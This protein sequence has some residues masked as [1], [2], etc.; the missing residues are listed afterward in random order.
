MTQCN[1]T[2]MKIF[3]HHQPRARER[4]HIRLFERGRTFSFF[5]S[6]H[7]F[8]ELDL[9]VV[10][11]PNI[12]LLRGGARDV[13]DVL[14]DDDDDDDETHKLLK[15]KNEKKIEKMGFEPIHK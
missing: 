14:A 10:R 1:E 6:F 4:E 3:T 8:V 13:T 9:K 7:F 15:Q 11:L 5:V 12:L 2:V